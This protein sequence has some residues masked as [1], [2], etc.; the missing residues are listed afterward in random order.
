MGPAGEGIEEVLIGAG[1]VVLGQVD[2]DVVMSP[3]RVWSAVARLSV[4]PTATVAG[5]DLDSLDQRWFS[6]AEQNGVVARDGTFLVSLGGVG[7]LVWIRVKRVG[8]VT[9]AQSIART[10]RDPEFVAMNIGGDFVCAVTSEEYEAWIIC[11][12]V[13][14]MKTPSLT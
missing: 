5:D 3:Q 12:E 11:M 8:V 2:P 1:L 14:G 7:D 4:Q 6:L 10:G 9:L 13:G